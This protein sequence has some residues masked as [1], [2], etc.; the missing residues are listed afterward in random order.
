MWIAIAANTLIFVL[1]V[2]AM[3]A[4]FWVYVTFAAPASLTAT[5]SG[6]VLV[7]EASPGSLYLVGGGR[8][9]QWVGEGRVELRAA[10]VDAAYSPL[11]RTAIELWDTDGA[12]VARVAVPSREF[13]VILPV[14]VKS[15]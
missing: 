3:V 15:P 8:D 14:V 6:D 2:A 13:V 5:W 11:G 4:L 10:G 7:V 9:P 12:V 1:T